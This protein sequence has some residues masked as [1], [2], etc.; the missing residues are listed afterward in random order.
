MISFKEFLTEMAWHSGGRSI[1]TSRHW[2][3][4]KNPTRKELALHKKYDETRIFIHGKD[5]YGW[6][7]ETAL[8][9]DIET[10]LGHTDMIPGIMDHKTKKVHL[11]ANVSNQKEFIAN[12]PYFKKLGYTSKW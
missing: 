11:F 8:H 6:N 1:Y 9:K 4:Y 2:E 10:H 3:L 12:H 7:P 5:V